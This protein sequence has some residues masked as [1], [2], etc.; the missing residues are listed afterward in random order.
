MD[1]KAQKTDNIQRLKE[2]KVDVWYSKD[3][4]FNA[5]TR[6]IKICNNNK[7]IIIALI[8]IASISSIINIDTLSSSYK[9]LNDIKPIMA[10]I[11]IIGS[12][13]ATCI[14]LVN[15]TSNS[16]ELSIRHKQA[17]ENFNHLFKKIKSYESSIDTNT[18]R[19]KIDQNF[20]SFLE[21][22]NEI[23]NNSPFTKKVDYE[24]AKENFNNKTWEYK[25]EE[26]NL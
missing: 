14:S 16:G 20:K 17:G 3:C 10:I 9:W 8:L 5:S 15:P 4:H 25:E 18:D 22:Q 7:W 2:L 1:D 13:I 11:G 21:K 19:E 26:L 23:C 6:I 24:Q 12:A